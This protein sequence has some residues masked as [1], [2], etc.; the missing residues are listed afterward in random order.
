MIRKCLTF[1]FLVTNIVVAETQLTWQD[2]QKN[3]DTWIAGP[4][5]LV[6]TDQE[7]AVFKKL[8]TP[9]EKMQF[10]KI[11]WQRRD[12]I[13]RTREN[14]FKDQFY[15]RVDYANEHFAEGEVP[16]WKTARG[17]VYILMGPPSR[18]EKRA[19]AESS[20]PAILW[21]Y[22]NIGTTRIP[23]NEALVFIYREFKYVLLP[24]SAQDGDVIG[25][26][27]RAQELTANRY[28]PIPSV[29]QQ[30][31]A[32]FAEKHIIDEKKDYRDLLSSVSTTVKFGMSGIDF[33]AVKVQDNPLQFKL[34]MSKE[35]AP[36]FDAGTS[37]FLEVNVDQQ[38]KNETAVL[39]SNHKTVSLQWQPKAFDGLSMIEIPLQPLQACTGKCQLVV[40]VRD[41]VSGVS[42][43][44][45]FPVEPR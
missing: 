40:T 8:N 30:V 32:D 39:D 14:E 7:K 31:F 12:P 28:Q 13:L 10:I 37:L 42:E 17:Q 5:S 4:V 16:G 41:S 25:A 44:R 19:I 34:T 9:E 45:T 43:T 26:E 38:L 6:A 24:P 27:M 36:V 35:T 29:V 2:L 23:A 18:E 20:R 15:D 3:I 22:D 21:I 1:L 33:E 11:F